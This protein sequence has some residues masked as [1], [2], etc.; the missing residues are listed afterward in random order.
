MYN[1]YTFVQQYFAHIV[2]QVIA[3]ILPHAFF[4]AQYLQQFLNEE[5]LILLNVCM[6]IEDVHVPSIL[7]F[8]PI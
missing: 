4:Y 3:S 7:I 6:D 2:R 5:P 8:I 1:L